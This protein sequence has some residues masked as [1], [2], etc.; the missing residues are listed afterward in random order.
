MDTQL[1]HM[2]QAAAATNGCEVVVV[3]TCE[4]L[5]DQWRRAAAVLIGVDMVEA[6][7]S[8]A[9]PPRDAVFLVGFPTADQTLFRWSVPLGASVIRLPEGAKWLAR[10]MAGAPGSHRNGTVVEVRG[11]AGGVGASTLSV[12]L[13]LRAAS[14]HMSVALVDGDHQGGGLD[15]IM[16]GENTP[17]WRWDKLRN[18]VG[19]IADISSMLPRIDGVSL[20]SMERQNPQEVPPAAFEAVV[21]ALARTHD[22]VVI[23]S[24]RHGPWVDLAT[25][26]VLVSFQSVR[27]MSATKAMM[28]D[29][30]LA[31]STLVLRHRSGSVSPRDS[32]RALG[33]PL[34][35]VVPHCPDLPRLADRGIPPLLGGR[36]KK[37]C[38]RVLTW[39]VGKV[40]HHQGSRW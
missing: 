8:W 20:V 10:V 29:Q 9:L 15:L 21:D 16:G 4:D 34:L 11:G 38:T 35:G 22:V 1:I 37:V 17:G 23:D 19:Q 13:A 14:A 6:V 32:A 2:A 3:S 18:A 7:S 31:D 12:G 5:R 27:A 28:G 26:H 33:L 40:T 39:S 30:G 25:R 24:P 36:W